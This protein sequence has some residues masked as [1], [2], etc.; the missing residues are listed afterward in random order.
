[1]RAA[2]P[3]PIIPPAKKGKSP[4]VTIGSPQNTDREAHGLGSR[5][6]ENDTDR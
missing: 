2:M 5:L 6:T 3:G 4:V 1:M